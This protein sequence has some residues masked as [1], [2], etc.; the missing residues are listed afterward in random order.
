VKKLALGLIA[1]STTFAVHANAGKSCVE[2]SDIVGYQQCSEYGTNWANERRP[3]LTLSLGEHTMYFSPLG[4]NFSAKL[5]KNGPE[6]YSFDGAELGDRPLVSHGLAWQITGYAWR[7]VYLGVE[8]TWAFGKSYGY[9]F[10]SNGYEVSPSGFL[11]TFQFA[12]GLL[13][14]AR[15]PLGK[16]SVRAE[17]LIGGRVISLSQSAVKDGE[18]KKASAGAAAWALEPRLVLDLWASP[19]FTLSAFGGQDILDRRSHSFGLMFVGHLRAYDGA[20]TL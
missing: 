11:D 5:T 18:T 17:M 13:V 14:G 10:S 9:S 7:N 20:F 8:S 3:P 1:A 12:G 16:L 19:W 6:A 4:R 2:T 15:V